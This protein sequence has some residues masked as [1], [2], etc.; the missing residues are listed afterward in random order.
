MRPLVPL[1]ILL[2][3]TL[4][5]LSA[6]VDDPTGNDLFCVEATSNAECSGVAV[7]ATGHAT[8]R[9]WGATQIDGA[10]ALFPNGTAHCGGPSGYSPD[11]TYLGGDAVGVAQR[12]GHACV[13][14]ASGNLHCWGSYNYGNAGDAA[15][16]LGG[17]AVQA[18]AGRYGACATLRSGN[19]R[20]WG[21]DSWGESEGYSGGDATRVSVG[22]FEACALLASRD[23]AC[24][25]ADPTLGYSGHDAVDLSVGAS[26]SFAAAFLC[27][28]TS[29]GDVRC[30]GDN[31]AGQAADHLGV[32]A[33]R[34]STAARHTCA[35][36]ASGDVRCWGDKSDGSAA[37][38][39]G[40]DAIAVTTSDAKTCALLANGVEHCWPS[41]QAS[42][43]DQGRS[44]IA[45]SGTGDAV[46]SADG[47]SATGNASGCRPYDG[48]TLC[49]A[50]SGPA[51][52]P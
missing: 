42:A 12:N 46:A 29:G 51:L 35:T 2:A 6:G 50:V 43:D 39:L 40:G 9:W 3:L 8:G 41:T 44:T 10:C 37:D 22:T 33:T 15:D 23:V 45:V 21:D 14:L 17:D 13:V 26:S 38:Y 20:C 25:G 16:Y 52:L 7:S 30:L 28:V 24:W 5:P 34:V 27:V 19:V 32:G 36:L 31:A 48:G 1:T 4:V 49:G 18:S 11:D 47:V